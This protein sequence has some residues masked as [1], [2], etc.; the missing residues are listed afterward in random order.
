MKRAALRIPSRH[1]SLRRFHD[2]TA[3]QQQRCYHHL[4]AHMNYARL[5]APMEDPIMSEFRLAMDPVNALA[6]ATPGFVWSLD[7]TSEDLRDEVPMLR[8]DPLLM[9]QLSLWQNLDAIQHF[10]FKSGHAMYL[11]RKREWFTAPPEGPVA[12]CWWR[13]AQND[14]YP[15]LKEA[16]DRLELLH[17]HGPTLEAFDF[18][19]SKQFPMPSNTEMDGTTACHSNPNQHRHQTEPAEILLDLAKQ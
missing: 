11:K 16:F 2:D 7:D 5:K 1:H 17:T 14:G 12:V 3:Q 6:K 8:Q 18:K 9:P 15:T 13:P 10:A 19:S 4:L